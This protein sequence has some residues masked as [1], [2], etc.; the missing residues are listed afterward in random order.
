LLGSPSVVE[1]ELSSLY[2]CA[3]LILQKQIKHI[4]IKKACLIVLV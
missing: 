3:L 4:N 1:K 2:G